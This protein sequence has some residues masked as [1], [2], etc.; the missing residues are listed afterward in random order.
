MIKVAIY[1]DNSGLREV[2]ATIIRDTNDMELTGEFGHCIDIIRNT[3]AFHPHVIIMDIDM[4]GKSGIEGVREVKEKFPEIEIIMNTVFDDDER[5]FDALKAGATGYLL[6]KSSLAM[7]LS[8]IKDVTS[9][10]APMS[11]AIA[12]KVLTMNFSHKKD[13][14]QENLTER[15]REILNLL[16]KGKSYKMIADDINLSIDTI[17]TH[18]KKIYQKLHVHSVTEALN[19]TFFNN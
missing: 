10:G 5:V 19:K 18:I 1:E 15:E 2:L 16:S 11:P 3:E 6:K 12:R 13:N 9:G 4:P 17:R 14:M 8:S 7:L